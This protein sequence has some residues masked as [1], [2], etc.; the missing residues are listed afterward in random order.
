MK[1]KSLFFSALCML[2][3]GVSFTACSDD[4][5]GEEGSKVELPYHR[6]YI[7]NEGTFQQNNASITLYDPEGKVSTI[8]D[9]YYTQNNASLGDTGQ[10]M[11]KYDNDLYVTVYGSNY[12]TRLNAAG[13]EQVRYTFTD[14]QGQPRYMT[15]E[16]GKIYVTLSSSNVARLDAKT[17]KFEKMVKV[18]NNPEYII[19]EDDKLYCLNSGWGYD[20]R[21]SIIDLKT[22]D[23]A[24]NI[25]VFLNPEKI[26]EVNDKIIIQ[27]YGA[28]YP[29]YT[30]PVAV[31]NPTTETYTTIGKGTHIAG[32][33]HL[34]YII[35]SNT[36]NGETNQFYTYNTQTGEVNNKSFLQSASDKLTSGNITLFN[37]NPENGDLYIGI[38][39]YKTKH[40]VY[41]FKNDGT[42]IGTFEVGIGG[43]KAIFLD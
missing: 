33:K 37:I 22:F 17:L 18:G 29:N 4:D 19:E 27:G 23:E 10:D 34:L 21:L 36:F 26:I 24:K 3:I 9:L 15:A 12:I 5:E 7:L 41:R 31:F 30:Y 8:P 2:M 11:I 16:D 39:D 13:I 32:Y 35:Y 1:F 20:N 38:G 6:V 40:D 42:L 25:E 43:K 14:E 28:E